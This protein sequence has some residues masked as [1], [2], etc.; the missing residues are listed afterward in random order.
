MAEQL[1]DAHEAALGAA[2][3]QGRPQAARDAARAAQLM[4]ALARSAAEQ[5]RQMGITPSR[6][7]MQPGTPTM[8]P[9]ADSRFGTGPQR[10][11]LSPA[12]LRE[13]GLSASD[14]ARLPGQLRDQVLQAS[15]REGSAEYRSVIRRYFKT[16]ARKSAEK[17]GE[18][19]RPGQGA[20]EDER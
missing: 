2:Q 19:D 16:L 8:A 17:N 18:A 15:D 1:A 6:L 3:N 11:D 13:L 20:E 12:R 4:A 5:A 7:G 9:S 14:W 10:A